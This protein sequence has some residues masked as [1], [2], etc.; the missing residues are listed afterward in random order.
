AVAEDM[1]HWQA[2]IMGP[3]DSPYAG[4]V[5]LVTIHFPPDYPF[6]PLKVFNCFAQHFCL[7]FEAF[8][9]G[10]APVYIAFLRF[11]GDDNDAKN[12]S[13]SLEVGGSGRKLT[14]QGIPRSTRDS[15][16][17]VRYSHDGLIIQRNMALF[18]SGS[19]RRIEA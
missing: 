7:H 10:T 1:F 13:Y 17:K 8:Q 11:M 14:C 19:D 18:F 15:H 12:F 6:K 9:L 16:R 3:G 4:G 2:T 5:F